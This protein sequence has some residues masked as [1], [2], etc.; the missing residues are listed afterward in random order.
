MVE[1]SANSKK[2]SKTVDKS[3]VF[4]RLRPAVTGTGTGHDMDGG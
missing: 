3:K 4:V 1:T 2:G